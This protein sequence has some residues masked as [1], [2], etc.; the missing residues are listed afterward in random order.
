MENKRPLDLDLLELQ[1]MIYQNTP[2]EVLKDIDFVMKMVE[3]ENPPKIEIEESYSGTCLQET[4]F[5][6]R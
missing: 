2:S 5:I 1:K 4:K 6:V 3:K